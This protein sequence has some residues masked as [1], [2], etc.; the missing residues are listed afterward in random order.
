MKAM[1]DPEND[2]RQARFAELYGALRGRVWAYAARRVGVD[3]ADD[4]TAETFMT[5]WRKLDDLPPEPLPWLYGVARHVV[6]RWYA[7]RERDVAARLALEKE[8]SAAE[9]SE[10]GHSNLW[11]AWR[12]LSAADREVLALVAWE[13]LRVGEAA[14][15]LGCSSPVFSVRLHRARRRFERLLTG[16]ASSAVDNPTFSVSEAS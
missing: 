15:V 5:A 13:G 11:Q 14:R 1:A 7:A 8:R 3:A 9:S 16:T 4:V 2:S 12:L 6:L 10:H